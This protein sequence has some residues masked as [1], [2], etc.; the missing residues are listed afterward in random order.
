MREEYEEQ[1]PAAGLSMMRIW[2]S[3]VAIALLS[4]M[5]SAGNSGVAGIAEGV[6]SVGSVGARGA[7][8]T[9]TTIVNSCTTS[10]CHTEITDQKFMHTPVVESKC[11]D[12]HEYAFPEEHLFVLTKP[13]NELCIDCHKPSKLDR[14]IHEPIVQGDCLSCHDPHGSEHQTI[15]RKAPG[16]GLC[17]DCHTDDYSKHE[18]VHGPVAVGACVVCHESHSS[19]FENLLIASPDRLCLDCHDELTPSLLEKKHQHKPMEEGCVSCHDPHASDEQFQLNASV[20]NLCIEC[21]D[22]FES[23]LDTAP[24]I[25]KPTMEPGGC[26]QCHNPHFSPFPKLQKY[27][28][29]DLCF[30]CHDK[31]IT[32]KDGRVLSDM[33]TF[34]EEN[35][36]HHGPIREGSCT[37]CHH[38]HASQDPNLLLQAYPPEFYAPFSIERYELCFSCHQADL[39]TDEQ[40]TGLTKFRQGDQNLHWVHVNREK[41]RTCRACHEVHASK[42]PAHIRESVPFGSKGWLL[43]IN[44]TQLPDGGSCAPACHKVKE[45]RRSGPLI[46]DNALP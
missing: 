3:I 33:K 41:G 21:H 39:V 37:M 45:Y 32:M 16:Q 9:P 7:Q 19:S 23:A 6:G 1:S 10:G 24:V 28:Q 20:P 26:T 29:P 17:L 8:P 42:R 27:A 22:W 15:L 18:F 5:I 14:V 38:P 40:G 36:D 34:L 13:A 35:P 31:P 43:D 44:F 12:C 4:M 2:M 11:L 30:K 25:H 46:I